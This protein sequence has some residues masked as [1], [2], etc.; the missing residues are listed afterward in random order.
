MIN[1]IIA[2]IVLVNCN[3]T[4]D[5]QMKLVSHAYQPKKN[6]LVYLP[7][8]PSQWKLED[9]GRFCRVASSI[10]RCVNSFTWLTL[11][12]AMNDSGGGDREPVTNINDSL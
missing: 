10:Y 12:S 2:E 4:S 9:F 7:K 8:F 5:K 6:G 3:F 1:F 11:S